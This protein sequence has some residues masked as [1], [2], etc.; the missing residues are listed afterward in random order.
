MLSP[1]RDPVWRSSPHVECY[2]TQG[3]GERNVRTA[4]ALSCSGVVRGTSTHI[5]SAKA[6][7]DGQEV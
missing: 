4:R 5:S 1:V 7:V 2:R 3:G 6:E